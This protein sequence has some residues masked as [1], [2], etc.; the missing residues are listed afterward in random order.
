MRNRTGYHPRKSVAECKC[1]SYKTRMSFLYSRPRRSF[2]IFEEPKALESYENTNA[3]GI[4]LFLSEEVSV[5][6]I[7]SVQYLSVS[8]IAPGCPFRIR[9]GESSQNSKY[10][11]TLDAGFITAV[12]FILVP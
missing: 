7:F 9:I 3:S 10:S 6:R 11:I 12:T 5:A 1:I 2:K 4:P 8:Y